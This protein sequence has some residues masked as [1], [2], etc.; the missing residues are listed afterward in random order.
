MVYLKEIVEW[1]FLIHW[2]GS[3]DF[4]YFRMEEKELMNSQLFVYCWPSLVCPYHG[5]SF[6][7]SRNV[8]KLQW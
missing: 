1:D 7:P 2:E 8:Q 3:S 5:L 4:F 6:S